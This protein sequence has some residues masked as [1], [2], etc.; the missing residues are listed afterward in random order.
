MQDAIYQA[1]CQGNVCVTGGGGVGKTFT[2]NAVIEKLEKSKKKF[3][4]TALTGLAST[5]LRWGMTIHSFSGI[6]NFTSIHDFDAIKYG[7]GFTA[8]KKHIKDID[9]LIIDEVSM[10]RPDTFE[11]V[12]GV[13][14]FCRDDMTTPFGGIHVM[15][16]GDFCQLPP[17]IGREEKLKE[18]WIFENKTWEE[19]NIKVFNL[20]EIKRQSD[21][22][23]INGL[24]AMRFGD[25]NQHAKW[26]L[27][28]CK[29][30]ELKNEAV[31]LMSRRKDVD[32][33][34]KYRLDLLASKEEYYTA[35]TKIKDHVNDIR[36]VYADL[37]DK[38]LEK[39]VMLK[40]GSKVMITANMQNGLK[41]GMTGTY[42]G[43]QKGVNADAGDFM[44]DTVRILLDGDKPKE[45]G[46]PRLRLSVKNREGL[47]NDEGEPL[48]D[49]YI[50]QF[51]IKLASA[52][53]IHKSQ[54]MTLENVMV[55]S[56]GIFAEGQMYV[57][58]SRAKSL[59]GLSIMGFDKRHIKANY[60]AVE[61]YRS[62][63]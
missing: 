5:H 36:R 33:Y 51:P 39:E 25:Y 44:N 45:V 42:L 14:R 26:L 24:N 19:A 57:A 47:M 55:D 31:V 1:L 3:A 18:Q 17:V 4:V 41:N 48:E 6:R 32:D 54:G 21:I 16:V 29:D 12:D 37:M 10:W 46:L 2:T 52:I 53:T 11:L 38:G 22:N 49:G 28:E 59:E 9:V 50:M 30:R 60:K 27:K 58:A 43:L 35:I 34:N 63:Q 23:L 61:F 62:L 15:L 40:I 20:T 13:C 56:R 8:V 7:R